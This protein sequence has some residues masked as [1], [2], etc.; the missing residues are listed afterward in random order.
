[1]CSKAICPTA[2]GD[3]ARPHPSRAPANSPRRRD[4]PGSPF[5]AMGLRRWIFLENGPRRGLPKTKVAGASVFRAKVPK[6][7]LPE[8]KVPERKVPGQKVPGEKVPRGN[9]PVAGD[10][11]QFPSYAV[12]HRPGAG[13]ID[14]G[15]RF[16]PGT[17]DS[18]LQ[19]RVDLYRTE[20]P[21]SRACSAADGMGVAGPE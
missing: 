7:K 3:A 5:A 13:P 8:R 6:P 15:R 11:D 17:P 14:G 18:G 20:D 21:G 16:R 12:R 2:K 1:M 4:L 10:S 9:G 19:R